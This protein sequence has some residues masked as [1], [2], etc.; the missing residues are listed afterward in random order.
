MLGCE[1]KTPTNNDT[2]SI[3]FI[4]FKPHYTRI[5]QDAEPTE[6][7]KTEINQ[8][9]KILNKELNE[10]N[11]A[12]KMLYYKDVEDL[13]D[14]ELDIS[15]YIIS[16]EKYKRQYIAVLNKKG[17]KEVWVNCFCDTW[18]ENWRKELIVVND[19][20]NCY[21]QLKINLSKM[22]LYGFRVNGSA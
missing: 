1:Y 19:G 13:K 11:S 10:Y 20:G 21:F 17:E 7:T 22:K 9:E 5:F 3:A 18:D 15:D 14:I 12:Q 16:L 2:L 6:L 8:I 4:P